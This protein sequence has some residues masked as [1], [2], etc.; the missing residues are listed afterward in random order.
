L[1]QG[2]YKD[3]RMIYLKN[4]VDIDAACQ[5]LQRIIRQWIKLVE[6]E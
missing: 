5:E 1:L 6:A 3:R 4:Q 2:D